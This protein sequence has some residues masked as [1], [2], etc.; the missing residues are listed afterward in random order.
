MKEYRKIDN[1][2]KFDEKYR[3]VVGYNDVYNV[4]KNI[5]WIGTEKVDGTNIRIY[6]DGH[7]I[8]IAGRTDKAE[9][10]KHLMN[11]LSSIFLTQEMEYVFEQMFGEKEVYLFG[12]GYG[13]KIQKDGEKYFADRIN[14]GF[15]LFDVTVN[16][17]DLSRE[18][19]ESIADKLNLDVVPIVF[20]GTLD[21][22]LEFVKGNPHSTLGDSTHEMEGLVL[23]PSVLLFDHKLRPIKCKLKYRDVAKAGV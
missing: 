14:V 1:V 13:Y 10:P 11:Y 16:G 8:G 22:A 23:Q 18:N 17:Y 15:I 5:E 19:V 4:L 9:I 6:W 3:I 21:D 20:K 2:F 12:E 7:N